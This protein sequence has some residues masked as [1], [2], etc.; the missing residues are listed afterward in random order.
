[1]AVDTDVTKILAAAGAGDDKA[2]DEL[3]PL[4]YTQLRHLAGQMLRRERPGQTLQATALVHEAY[5]RLVGHQPISWQD[6]RHFYNAAAIAMR[7]ILVDRARHRGRIKHGGNHQRIELT[8]ALAG[9]DQ[10]SANVLAAEAALRRL[11][12]EDPRAARVVMFRFFAGL[13]LE[14]TALAMGI[15]ERT[16]RRDWQFAR[17]WL[18]RAIRDARA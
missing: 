8:Q 14:E 9:D 15:S 4:V 17:T 16:A 5:L 11:E 18:S 2:A 1:M 10:Q 6:R 13:T 3:L 7:R 12:D